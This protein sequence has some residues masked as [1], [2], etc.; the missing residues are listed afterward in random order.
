MPAILEFR[1]KWDFLSNFYPSPIKYQGKEYKTVEHFFQAMK[2]TNE[3]DHEKVRNAP[4]PGA[5]KRLGRSI[6]CRADWDL[7]KDQFMLLGLT[8]KFK[9]GTILYNKLLETKP[10][11]L[12]EGNTW[13]DRYWGTDPTGTTGLNM[14]GQLLMRIRDAEDMFD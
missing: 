9:K 10:A 12:C 5:A 6:T 1:G 7:V 11:R 13:N 8:L 3:A 4:T 2:A 14:L